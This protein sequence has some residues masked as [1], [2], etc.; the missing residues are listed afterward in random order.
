MTTIDW[1]T[2]TIDTGGGTLYGP[3]FSWPWVAMGEIIN[4]LVS[5]VASGNYLVQA[6]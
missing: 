2:I 5:A 3:I 6:Q 4:T 1:P